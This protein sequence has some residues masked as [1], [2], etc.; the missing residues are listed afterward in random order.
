MAEPS[1]RLVSDSQDGHFN[2]PENGRRIFLDRYALKDSDRSLDKLPR[3]RLLVITPDPAKAER[4]IALVNRTFEDP[5]KGDMVEVRLESDPSV[6]MS[7]RLDEVDVPIETDP[8]QMHERVATAV[9]SVEDTEETQAYWRS[10]FLSRLSN[11]EI[12]PGGR[13]YAS[14]GAGV[15]TTCYNCYVL[16]P[17]HDS[18]NMY[19]Y[20]WNDVDISEWALQDGIDET[21]SRMTEIFSRG[22]GVGIPINTLR[23]RDAFVAGVNGRSSGSVSWAEEYSRRTGKIEQGGS[24]RGALMI[25]QSIWHPDILHFITAKRDM[26]FATNCNMSVAITDEFMRS[27]EVGEDWQLVFPDT[28]FD[29]YDP[30][31]DGDI[32][33]WRAKDY[34]VKVYETIPARELWKSIYTS[35]HAS[36]EPGLFFVDRYNKLS[37]S[38]YY[39]TGKI[40]CTNPCVTGD[41]LVATAEHGLIPIAHLADDFRPTSVPVDKRFGDIEK[42][43]L[44]P[45][46]NAFL[47]KKQADVFQLVTKEGY[48]LK[49]TLDHRIMTPRGWV[50]LQALRPGDK[51]HISNAGGGFGPDKISEGLGAILGWLVGD[52]TIKSD[53]AVLSF[54][55]DERELVDLFI[56][57]LSA[58]V[59]A[60]ANGREYT[61]QGADVEE[62]DETRI[63]SLRLRELADHYGLIPDKLQVP[64]AV[65][66]TSEP[67]QAA[68]LSALFTADGGVQGSAEKGVSVRLASSCLELLHEVQTMLLNFQ[69][70]CKV[71]PERRGAGYRFLP[72]GKGGS[73]RYWCNADHELMISKEN[74]FAFRARIGFMS[75]RK[76]RAL[77]TALESYR[78]R[79][80]YMESFTATVAEIIP[81]GQEDVYDLMVPGVNAFSAN[82]IVVHNCGE[83]GIPG[84][85]VCNL[86]HLYLARFMGDPEQVYKADL[87]VDAQFECRGVDLPALVR[88]THDAMRFGDNVIEHTHY[89]D[90]RNENQQKSERRVGLGTLGLAELL[91]R[92]KV[93]YGSDESLEMID[94]IYGTIACAAYAASAD[95]AEERGAFPLF[96][97]EKFLES[98]FMKAM[99]EAVRDNILEKGARFVAA[100]S[101]AP[102]GTT[103]S[104]LGTSTSLEAYPWLVWTRTSSLGKFVEMAAPFRE[105]WEA[106]KGDPNDL[107][108]KDLDAYLDGM[109]ADGSLPHHFMT[110]SRLVPE[111]HAKVQAAIQRWTDASIS[112]TANLPEHYTPEQVGEYYQLIYSLG[113]KG[114][115][116]YRDGSRDAQPLESIKAEP[117]LVDS[118]NLMPI[119]GDVGRSVWATTETP[120]GKVTTFARVHPESKKP[121]DMFQLLGKTGTDVMADQEAIGR[122][123]SLFLRINSPIDPMDR[124]EMISEALHGIGGASS[125]GF[126]EKKVVSIAD[127][128]AHNIDKLLSELRSKPFNGNG[129]GNARKDLCPS[130]GAA[131]L[132]KG[133]GCETCVCGFSRC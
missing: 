96:D 74:L 79:G 19:K 122:M 21:L 66:S 6:V 59:R 64:L 29:R 53:A 62:R 77:D 13:V 108:G 102:T 69:I 10:Q 128:V 118:P 51:V 115:T 26:D 100:M 24:R 91:M 67:G 38:W 45:V 105:W 103:G 131:T 60:S 97:A 124:M 92:L 44:A 22:G 127:G 1:V 30:E 84:N 89:F 129:N 65:F 34:P 56:Q 119:P 14:A 78:D 98:G 80:P 41:T 31:W 73:K 40:W 47:T 46:E 16:P 48:A 111:G 71:Y 114:G 95:L 81:A 72:D 121:F 20:K 109:W 88:A 8:E 9:A 85:A 93:E 104:M 15:E 82:G 106:N 117:D 11:Y 70:A 39:P 99:P 90:P 17:P 110:A 36:A 58:E 68:F 50:P 101:Q 3:N 23:P 54:W 76:K 113:C 12:V 86:L 18:R 2:L 63:E 123:M 7:F 35:A 43:D 32:D 49:A 116:V 126:G 27:V 25:I 75:E 120:V 37:N 87:G 55:R 57:Y 112:K 52:G 107:L 94:A 5:Q 28:S 130:C 132:E 33:S 61:F 133:A 125:V 42:Y 4:E 83:Q